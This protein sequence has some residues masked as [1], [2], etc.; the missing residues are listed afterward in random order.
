MALHASY[1]IHTWAK[2]VVV[3]A[4]VLDGGETGYSKRSKNNP[5]P[6][7][8]SF[9]QVW[10][11]HYQV[12]AFHEERVWEP[13]SG[14][15]GPCFSFADNPPMLSCPK[16]DNGELIQVGSSFFLQSESHEW[17]MYVPV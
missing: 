12:K 13:A 16:S 3:L 6:V 14:R 15:D 10:P 17:N 2:G 7:Q 8:R 1:F 9:L 11:E 5:T 4:A